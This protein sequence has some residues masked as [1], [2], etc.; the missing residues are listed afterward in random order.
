MFSLLTSHA[1]C[2]LYGAAIGWAATHWTAV[3]IAEAT[4]LKLFEK[5]ASGVPL[6]PVP[7]AA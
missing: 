5:K 1:A 7:P 6:A 2:L 4:V 3:K